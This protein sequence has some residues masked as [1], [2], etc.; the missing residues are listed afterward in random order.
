MEYKIRL[1]IPEMK[2]IWDDLNKKADGGTAS[3]AELDLRKKLG[4]TMALIAQNPRHPGLETH[5]IT[6]L[7]ARFGR[8]VW[9]SYL[10]NHTP[11]ARRIYW[12]YGPEKGDITI[13]GF[14][15]H[16][17]DRKNNSYDKVTLSQMGEII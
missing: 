1:G 13:L 16:P 8:K 14:E 15:P 17:E 12:C 3:K 7:T 10:G 4:K 9:Q 2:E 6:Q 11:G 5:E